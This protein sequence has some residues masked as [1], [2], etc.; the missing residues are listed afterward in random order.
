MNFIFVI[1]IG[2]ALLFFFWVASRRN[3][4]DIAAPYGGSPDASEYMV[5]LPSRAL[6]DRFL[7]AEDVE[8][9]A[10]LNSSALVRLVVRE[11]RRLA[12]VWLRQ[13]GREAGRLFRLHLRM[14]RQAEGLRPTAEVKL[15]FAVGSFFFVY[16]VMMAAVG[17]Y[18]T[19]RTRRFLESLQ[20]L[21]NVLSNLGGRIAEG[22]GSS[23]VPQL[24]A[25]GGR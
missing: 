18:G 1:A 6:L 15:V 22:I 20:T 24:D 5:H 25:G 13:N 16:A 2:L 3:T 9:A 10:T 21:A 4:S 17:L 11:R 12:T 14:V 8:Y 23:M 19:L 7:S